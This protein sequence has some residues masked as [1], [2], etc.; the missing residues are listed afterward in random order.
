MTSN[1]GRWCLGEFGAEL[2]MPLFFFLTTQT[3]MT[4][5]RR[6]TDTDKQM[7]RMRTGNGSSVGFEPPDGGTTLFG[8]TTVSG[9]EGK[10][11]SFV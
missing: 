5:R 10:K 2:V 4:T 7:T 3:T 11:I 1:V 9:R 8:K 6:K